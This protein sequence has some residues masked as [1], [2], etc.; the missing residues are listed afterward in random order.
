MK[1]VLSIPMGYQIVEKTERLPLETAVAMLESKA[2]R[3]IT[4]AIRHGDDVEIVRHVWRCPFCGYERSA[5]AHHLSDLYHIPEQP[6]S[7]YD[8]SRLA[9]WGSRQLSFWEGNPVFECNTPLLRPRGHCKCPGCF[10]SVSDDQRSRTVELDV[11]DTSFTLSLPLIDN[12]PLD[13]VLQTLDFAAFSLVSPVIETLSFDLAEHQVIWKWIDSAG[14]TICRSGTAGSFPILLPCTASTVIE[15]S[16]AVRRRLKRFF[17]SKFGGRPLPFAFTDLST[18]TCALMTMFTG[19]NSKFY[20]TL[21]FREF[22]YSVENSFSDVLS[23]L[24]RSSQALSLVRESSLP[25]TQAI[26]QLFFSENQGLLIYIAECEKL[27]KIVQDEDLLCELLRRDLIVDILLG[28]HLHTEIGEFLAEFSSVQGKDRLAHVLRHWLHLKP[29]IKEYASMNEDEQEEA[30]KEW[31]DPD[32]LHYPPFPQNKLYWWSTSI[33]VPFSPRH[34]ST[35]TDCFI[36]GYFFRRIRSK[37]EAVMAGEGTDNWLLRERTSFSSPA[38]FVYQNQ[39]LI[40]VIEIRFHNVINLCDNDGGE[41]LDPCFGP[42]FNKWCDRFDMHYEK[43][44]V[45]HS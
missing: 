15:D 7:V 5:Y 17:I 2:R 13:V 24:T 25:K 43:P 35:P 9:D 30:R 16:L 4:K 26:R 32:F 41:V 42:A 33:S 23:R 44:L 37:H 1:E 3:R 45:E 28:M 20:D 27:W 18:F 34:P 12:E 40:A 39:E 38:F 31:D 8:K 36:D 6:P 29:Y 22:S 14:T 19:W 21:P 10:R 11:T